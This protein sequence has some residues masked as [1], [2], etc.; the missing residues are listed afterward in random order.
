[1]LLVAES[2]YTYEV[3]AL[4][5]GKTILLNESGTVQDGLRN[6]D[7]YQKAERVWQELLDSYAAMLSGDTRLVGRENGQRSSDCIR[8]CGAACKPHLP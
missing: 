4:D 3:S 6:I 7:K 5:T 1:M 8:R 2:D